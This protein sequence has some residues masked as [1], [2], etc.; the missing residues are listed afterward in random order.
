[1]YGQC[2]PTSAVIGAGLGQGD[3][4]PVL[5]ADRGADRLAQSENGDDGQYEQDQGN[6]AVFGTRLVAHLPIPFVNNHLRNA[7]S[8]TVYPFACQCDRGDTSEYVVL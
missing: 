8:E 7:V 5:L 1:M 3:M 6:L 2:R 4:E